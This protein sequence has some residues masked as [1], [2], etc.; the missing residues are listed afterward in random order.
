MIYF[1]AKN[2][3]IKNEPKY[4]KN[5]FAYFTLF[6]WKIAEKEP[7]YKKSKKWVFFFNFSKWLDSRHVHTFHA[8]KEALICEKK[9]MKH[10][11]V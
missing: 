10:L 1:G 9:Q 8:A 5:K 4:D 3:F 11:P 7:K 2:F 6:L